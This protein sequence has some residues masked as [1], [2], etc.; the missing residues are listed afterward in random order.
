MKFARSEYKIIDSKK[1]LLKL[2]EYCKKTRYASVDFETN[3]KPVTSSTFLPTILGVSFQVGGGWIIPLAH[4]DSKFKDNWRELFDL[5]CKEVIE[6][7]DIVKI[8]W[9]L[10]FEYSIF[11][12]YNFEMEG[13]LLDGMLAKYLLDENSFNGLKEVVGKF[14]PPFKGYEAG[15]SKEFKNL[16]WDE[17]PLEELS[18]YCATD[19]DLTFR[20]MVFFERKLIDLGFY[21]LFRNMLMMGTRVLAES[22]L[23][24]MRIDVDYLDQLED[25]YTNR[26]EELQKLM[27]T[28]KVVKFER[29]LHRKRVKDLIQSV[30]DEIDKLEIELDEEEDDKKKKGI[31]RKIKNRRDKLL[32]YAARDFTTQKELE[33]LEPFN[34]SSPDQLKELLFY[35]KKGYR[36]DV[37]KYTVDK[38]TKRETDN[39]STDKDAMVELI[40]VDKDGFIKHLSEYKK[41]SKL[42]GTYIEGFQKRI[43]IDDCIHGRFL[44]HGTV[45]GRLS[46][47]EPNLQN[48]PRDT[49]AKEIKKM[50]IPP[51]GQLIFQLDYSQAELRVM[52]AQAGEKTMVQWFKEGR[53][54]HLASACKKHDWDYDWANKI[55]Q[56][57]DKTDPNFEKVK[58]ARKQAKT[59][60]FGIIYGQGAKHLSESLS[61]PENGVYVSV[62]EAQTFLDDFFEL[63]PAVKKFMDRQH[64]FVMQNGYVKNVFG[65]KRRLPNAFLPLKSQ[66]QK[67]KN[68]GKVAEAKRASVNAPIQGA[69]S[70]Y[71]LFSSI[72][73]WE[74]IRAGELPSS[75]R[76]VATVHDSLIYYIDPKDIHR[77]V[78]ILEK[79]C[80]NPQ[81]KKFFGF[82]IDDVRM[83]VDFE[84]G[85]TWADLKTYKPDIDYTT[86]VN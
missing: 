66:Q 45:T 52:A 16:P 32:R 58:V 46:S 43:T 27:R 42:F 76:Q 63:F 38:S 51:D 17:K 55:L 35:S 61:D 86:L 44:L 82:Q 2:I 29:Y 4:K 75:L 3:A 72:I 22:E 83:K 71:T 39:P 33:M 24:G 21:E 80:E 60:N 14:L 7:P 85:E 25:E 41:I 69:A 50:F 84:V 13:I 28:R 12:K 48:I 73:I 34:P 67:E 5:F 8:S 37:V 36:Y 1:E 23:L 9:N 65:R 70:D 56:K 62:K 47:R 18:Q 54:I 19:C 15:A 77:V 20:L 78:P 40:K 31:E 74:K 79:V 6:N 30:E 81:T 11:L 59:I 10:K 49:T 57:E 26:L 68:W 64:K 53:D